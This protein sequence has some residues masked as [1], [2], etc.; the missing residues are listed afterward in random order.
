[1]PAPL[2]LIPG[3]FCGGWCFEEL[4]PEL[5][6]SG[7]E[8][9]AIDLP[10]HGRGEPSPALLSLTDYARFVSELALS[11]SEPPVLVGHSMGGLVAQ[12]AAARVP[13][14]GLVLLA[15]S[16]VW[17]QPVT[18]AVE[19]A[20]SPA[21]LAMKGPYWLQPVEPDWPV[22]RTNTLDALPEDQARAIYARMVPESGRVLYETLSW[23]AD[24][25]MAAAVPPLRTPTM[26]VTGELD[27][28]HAA[29]STEAT[30]A[31]LHGAHH[32]LPGVSHWTIG[33]PGT[34]GLAGMILEFAG[35]L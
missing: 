8:V 27:R 31:R 4:V 26:V 23:W 25:T 30:A 20:A 3:A 17:G 14:A 11:R 10:G 22:V 18:S 32:V 19:L 16:P 28:V 21:L 1:M 2:L 5:E 6:R 24:P 29:S 35:R 13:V 15:P 34:E 12:L 33:G 7:R 9:R